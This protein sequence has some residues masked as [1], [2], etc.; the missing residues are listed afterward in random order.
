MLSL[1]VPRQEREG[2]GVTDVGM[3]LGRREREEVVRANLDINI[4]RECDGDER[5]G[6]GDDR[7]EKH[8][9]RGSVNVQCSCCCCS[10]MLFSSSFYTQ[11]SRN[12]P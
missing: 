11:L 9:G 4:C 2:D 10:D 7:L 8:G 6:E 12:V 3:Y 1:T 5:E